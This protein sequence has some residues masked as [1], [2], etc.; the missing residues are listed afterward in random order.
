MDNQVA[1]FEQNNDV[2]FTINWSHLKKT[3]RFEIIRQVPAL[4][5]IYEIYF[6]DKYKKLNR[7]AVSYCWYNSLRNTLRE[8]ADS[9]LEADPKR[10]YILDTYECYY[11]YCIVDSFKDIQDI[12]FTFEQKLDP[13]SNKAENSKRYNTIFIKEVSPDKIVTF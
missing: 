5:G 7:L 12:M 9:T 11:R 1:R 13:K 2:Y 10:K 8:K 6:M 4:A 3:D